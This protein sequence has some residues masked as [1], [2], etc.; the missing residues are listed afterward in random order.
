METS[1]KMG[2]AQEVK[3]KFESTAEKFAKELWSE[4]PV[5]LH[6]P[7]LA[8]VENMLRDIHDKRIAEAEQNLKSLYGLK[9]DFENGAG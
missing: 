4:F 5:E 1:E 2:S 3:E 6:K 9:E 8:T 7:V